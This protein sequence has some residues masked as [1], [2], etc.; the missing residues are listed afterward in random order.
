MQSLAESYLTVRAN[1]LLMEVGMQLIACKEE[2]ESGF[3][4]F[5]VFGLFVINTFSIFS[6]LL[7]N[8][9][10]TIVMN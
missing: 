10:I 8:R 1:K 2:S 4:M 9:M 6:N 5:S 3:L 7:Y